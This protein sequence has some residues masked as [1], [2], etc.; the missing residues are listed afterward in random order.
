MSHGWRHGGSKQSS[1]SRFDPYDSATIR[2]PNSMYHACTLYIVRQEIPLST[3]VYGQVW[4]TDK[5]FTV[6]SEEFGTH[7]LH[8]VF[9]AH[10]FLCK[11]R[12]NS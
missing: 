5:G 1:I 11:E 2:I 9:I 6:F 3:S 12:D 4:G 10:C 8:V 7:V